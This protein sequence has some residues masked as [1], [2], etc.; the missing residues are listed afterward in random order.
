MKWYLGLNLLVL[1]SACSALADSFLPIS[2]EEICRD[3][4]VLYQTVTP[5]SSR[6]YS[7]FSLSKW[8]ESQPHHVTLA[9]TYILRISEGQVYSTQGI[10]FHQRRIVAEQ[11]W[12]NNIGF[13]AQALGLSPQEIPEP[14]DVEGR[15]AVITQGGQSCY[16]HWLTEVLGRLA[17]LEISEI[18]YDNLYVSLDAPFKEQSLALWGIDPERIIEPFK[19]IHYGDYRSVK[20]D[21]LIVPSLIDR[22]VP[23]L[24]PSLSSYVSPWVLKYL[25]E[26]FIPKVQKMAENVEIDENK[27]SKK[28]FISRQDAEI[29]KISNEDA[30]FAELAP[31]GFTRYCLSEL[32]F[33]EQ[34]YLFSKAEQVI[35]VHGAGFA[36]IIFSPPQTKIVEI[37][38]ARSDSTYCYLAQLL[39][40]DYAAY[41]TQEFTDTEK[42]GCVDTTISEETL[43]ELVTE[44]T[45]S[46]GSL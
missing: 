32:N 25:R 41:K 21:Q 12:P 17:M 34:V 18:P 23:D 5:S 39:D 24:E 37:F 27:F 28:I 9:E 20:A 26:K 8:P 35:G 46:A 15:L 44:L 42:T 40:F 4:R 22:P 11:I 30:L 2:V 1:T 29:R 10:I 45:K 14:Q 13:K 43:K 36:N 38:Q 19:T 16:Y 3:S 6:N 31:L 7:P 33:A